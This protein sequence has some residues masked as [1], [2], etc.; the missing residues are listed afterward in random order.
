MKKCSWLTKWFNKSQT[1]SDHPPLFNQIEQ[2]KQNQLIGEQTAKMLKSLLEIGKAQVR[3]CMIPRGQIVLIEEHWSID[4]VLTVILESGHSRYPIIDQ[5]HQK[6]LG[7]LITKD[8]LPSLIKQQSL[9]D[10]RH[11]VRKAFIVPESRALDAV[12][13][14]F[15]ATRNHMALVMDEYGNLSG[16]ITIEDVLEEIVGE[17]DDEHDEIEDS[18]IKPN[19]D[20]SFQVTALTPII[21]FN[22]NFNTNLPDNDADTLGGYIAQQ[23]GK[24]PNLGDELMIEKW[25]IKVIK[26]N[27]RRALTFRVSKNK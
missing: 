17:I 24:V 10:F 26:A 6:I 16:L 18:P 1:K 20:G 27:Q 13:N 5:D 8:L 9:K 19:P 7:V 2:A 21:Q 14:D 3:D 22:Q 4:K 11:L 25:K 15:Q 23:L 12:L